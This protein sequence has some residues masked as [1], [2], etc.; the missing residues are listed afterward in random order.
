MKF[1]FEISRFCYYLIVHWWL[2][3]CSDPIESIGIK[4]AS[5]ITNEDKTMNI[6]APNN[7]THGRT[8]LLV[9]DESMVLEVG[10]T[11][12]QRLGHAVITATSAEQALAQFDQHRKTIGCVVL[13]L[14]MPG[15]DGKQA[16][17]KLRAQ[18]PRL[19][20]IIASGL[21]IDQ[22]LGQFQ[23]TPPTSVIQKPYQVADLSSKI[24]AV[25]DGN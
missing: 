15:M 8:V 1:P 2:C 7:P 12:L 5:T 19:P 14:S 6:D 16:F 18:S 25:L 11:I 3:Q 23:D 20:I 9:D 17:K 13:D 22:V 21:A 4:Q 10:K 24:Q